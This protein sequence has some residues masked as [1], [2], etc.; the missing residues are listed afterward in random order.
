MRWRLLA[1]RVAGPETVAEATDLAPLVDALLLDSGQPDAAIKLLGGTRWT[2]DW[3]ISRCIV[4]AVEAPVFL[5]GG[6]RPDNV[7]RAI[8]EVRPFGVI[9]A[10]ACVPTAGSIR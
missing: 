6:L 7:G 10:R 8:G 9:C 2:H 4:D 1:T 5:A 3:E